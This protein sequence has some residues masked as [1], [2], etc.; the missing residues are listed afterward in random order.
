VNE[1][2]LGRWGKRDRNVL[3]NSG[4]AIDD[5]HTR[6]AVR[7]VGGKD[8]QILEATKDERGSLERLFPSFA[9]VDLEIE[10]GRIFCVVHVDAGKPGIMEATGESLEKVFQVHGVSDPSISRGE[11]ARHSAWCVS[12]AFGDDGSRVRVPVLLQER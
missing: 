1:R 7:G 4:P 10:G 5:D 9:Y 2:A 3:T 12:F 11:M 6:L 8:D